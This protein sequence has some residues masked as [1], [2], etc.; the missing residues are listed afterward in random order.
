M[1]NR[2]L[3]QGSRNVG[4]FNEISDS[5]SFPPMLTK[6]ARHEFG[7][8]APPQRLMAGNLRVNQI[9]DRRTPNP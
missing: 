8:D 7:T 5:F 3:S 9:L 2:R 4:V 6:T 1:D